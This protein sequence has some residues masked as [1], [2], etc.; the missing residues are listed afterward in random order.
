MNGIAIPD[1][2]TGQ[3]MAAPAFDRVYFNLHGRDRADGFAVLGI[4]TYPPVNTVDAYLCLV[5]GRSAEQRNLRFSTEL[6]ASQGRVGPLRFHC[7]TPHKVWRLELGPNAAGVEFDLVWTSRTDVF[8]IPDYQTADASG[9]SR[10]A[11]LFQSGTWEGWLQID[12]VRRAVDGWWGQRDRSKGARRTH[13]QLGLHLWLQC[14]LENECLGVL[15]NEHRDNRMSH[16]HGAAMT[17]GG[18]LIPI[19]E[20]RHDLAFDDSFLLQG[21]TVS[22]GLADGTRRE[23]TVQST[24]PGIFM[25]GGGYAGWH[26]V[27]R[28]R[29]HREHERWPFDGQ[30]TPRNLRLGITDALCRFEVGGATGWGITEYALSRSPTF[31]YAAGGAILK[32]GQEG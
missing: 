14:Q 1:N 29:D 3:P 5:D 10:Y 9:S 22:L 20:L 32:K 16:F 8:E 30:R 18:G 12:G 13:D 17:A 21:G 31:T 24:G 23:M 2:L 25:E 15:Y 7:V 11:H 6:D 19:V 4:G 28:G 26:G 27:P